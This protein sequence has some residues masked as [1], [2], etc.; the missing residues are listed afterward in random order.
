MVGLGAYL[1]RQ[2]IIQISLTLWPSPLLALAG[3]SLDGVVLLLAARFFNPVA[4]AVD[5]LVYVSLFL[6]SWVKKNL[7]IF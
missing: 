5:I 7:L 6:E 2:N 1:W 3:A 4:A